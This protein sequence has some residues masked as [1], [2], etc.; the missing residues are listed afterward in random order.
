MKKKI[1]LIM[2]LVLLVS[3][4]F[5]STVYAD[6]NSQQQKINDTYNQMIENQKQLIQLYV[7]N[8][9]WTQQQADVMLQRMDQ[10]AKS[11]INPSTNGSQFNGPGYNC[12]GNYNGGGWNCNGY[13][14][15]GW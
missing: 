4:L 10:N 9:Q 14:S 3:A 7:D 8:G 2:A 15:R 13:G 12:W 11:N 6:T 5:I 1:Y